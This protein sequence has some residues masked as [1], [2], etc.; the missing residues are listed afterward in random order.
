MAHVVFC[1]NL[2]C[3]RIW[4]RVGMQGRETLLWGSMAM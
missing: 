4:A 2:D 3:P 1:V